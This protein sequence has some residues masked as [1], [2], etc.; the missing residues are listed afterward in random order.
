MREFKLV[1]E[2]SDG[3]KVWINLIHM[4]KMEKDPKGNYL[5][6]LTNGDIYPI[7]HSRARFVE[8]YFEGR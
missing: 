6:F 4:D 7:S 2:K 3:T 8:N 1:L 5:S